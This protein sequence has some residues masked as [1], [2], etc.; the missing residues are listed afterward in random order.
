MAVRP[1]AEL[2]GHATHHGSRR[3][4]R[5]VEERAQESHGAELHGT[6]QAHV[7]A[8]VAA[9]EGAVGVVKVEVT[10]KLLGAGLAGIATV[11]ARL[12]L[13]QKGDGHP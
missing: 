8:P 2:V 11:A 7:L 12:L 6:A 3:V 5:I 10:G 4:G 1:E 9:E 13:G